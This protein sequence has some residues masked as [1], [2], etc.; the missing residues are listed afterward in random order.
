MQKTNDLKNYE[1]I[2]TEATL[3]EEIDNL[4]NSLDKE[5]QDAE[6]AAKKDE[7][8]PAE[9]APAA[10]AAPAQAAQSITGTA[11]AGQ[12]VKAA[13]SPTHNGPADV[14]V[15]GQVVP[16]AIPTNSLNSNP[17]VVTPAVDNSVATA[18]LKT[19]ASSVD[20]TVKPSQTHD[21]EAQVADSAA[22]FKEQ[23]N[24]IIAAL[25]MKNINEDDAAPA[26]AQVAAATPAVAAH[27]E[28]PVAAAV[29]V[30]APQTGHNGE[31]AAPAKQDAAP[32]V[33][34]KLGDAQVTAEVTLNAG[35]EVQAADSASHNGP[36]NAGAAVAP[37]AAA[38]VET[39]SVKSVK[40]DSLDIGSEVKT[41][42]DAGHKDG[43][44][45]ATAAPVAPAA[46]NDK[47]YPA[48]AK[49]IEAK[50]AFDKDFDKYLKGVAAGE[51]AMSR[52]EF[53]NGWICPVG[54]KDN[55]APASDAAKAAAAKVE[56][57]VVTEAAD[58]SKVFYPEGVET[59][60]QKKAFNIAY[61]LAKKGN[62]GL[63]REDFAK[64]YVVDQAVKDAAEA[65]K[66][67]DAKVVK[68]DEAVVTPTA[69]DAKVTDTVV[70]AQD[71][72]NAGATD[73]H[74][75]AAQ[76]A[77]P[78]PTEAPA[79]AVDA[80]KVV[81][82][83]APALASEVSQ[84][85]PDVQAQDSAS[86]NGP[87]NAGESV[88]ADDSCAC[89]DAECENE[90][91]D[92]IKEALMKGPEFF[93][94]DDGRV[95]K[96]IEQMALIRAKDSGDILF[97]AMVEHASAAEKIRKRLCEKYGA[98]ATRQVTSLIE[99]ITAADDAETAAAAEADATK[100]F[101]VDAQI[102]SGDVADVG[103]QEHV[104][105]VAAVEADKPA[106]AGVSTAK[107]EPAP[108]V[109]DVAAEVAPKVAD[110]VKAD[111]DE[112]PEDIVKKDDVAG[113]VEVE[114]KAGEAKDVEAKKDDAAAK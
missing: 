92:S 9:A 96:L 21:G 47:Y 79:A 82:A 7:A 86:H 61:F 98:L 24:D 22:T 29:D 76:T 105:K 111:A 31:A 25:K 81:A 45:V 37:A 99:E 62:S 94:E 33:T 108:A 19:V 107:V 3:D 63:T 73:T 97:E 43:V 72:T 56:E 40:E 8:K 93:E 65:P 109:A 11:T 26:Q 53:A 85:Q 30:A 1:R 42:V 75:G 71:M 27:V 38:K 13:D 15:P 28:A 41:A 54:G 6:A 88:C 48:C 60:E 113:G 78:A 114:A 84:A 44:A 12:D 70:A 49:T 69:A 58:G 103:T 106:D 68:E 110:A 64:N 35:Q 2:T 52:E 17:A 23:M 90:S 87:A 51:K 101:D 91:Y 104:E 95:L 14:S 16:T 112:K 55:V 50:E 102:K 5:G 77:A 57:K 83:A 74:D 80:S 4:L 18:E 32:A 34:P 59:S 20:V 36:A 46:V 67:E 10:A 39:E 100:V 89:D 66:A